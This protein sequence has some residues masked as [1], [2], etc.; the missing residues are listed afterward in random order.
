MNDEQLA[1]LL[2]SQ[3]LRRAPASLEERVL[4]TIAAAPLTARARGFTGWP[5]ALQLLFVATALG[6]ALLALTWLGWAASDL[7][8]SLLFTVARA[9]VN[10]VPSL[11]LYAGGGLVA[12]LYLL[13]F[14]LGALAWRALSPTR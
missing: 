6:A 9:L 13:C 5:L 3:P 14:G 7:K 11:W 4:A 10:H 12:A 2:R 8:G 1:Q